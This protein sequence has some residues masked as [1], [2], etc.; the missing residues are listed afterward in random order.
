M[1]RLTVKYFHEMVNHSAGT[2]FVLSQLISFARRKERGRTSAMSVKTLRDSIRLRRFLHH[3]P[4]AL[5]IIA[6][7]HGA[8]LGK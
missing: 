4:R 2:N 8:A 7:L 3:H 6:K 5:C 1:T